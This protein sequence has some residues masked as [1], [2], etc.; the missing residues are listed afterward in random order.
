MKPSAVFDSPIVPK[1]PEPSVGDFDR[2]FGPAA[3][4]IAGVSKRRNGRAL[5]VERK[6]SAAAR[7]EA[8]APAL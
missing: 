1:F 5:T 7:A 6:R 4:L 8:L 2:T 3:G